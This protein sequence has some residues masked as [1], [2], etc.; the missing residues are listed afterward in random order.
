[1]HEGTTIP[2]NPRH[3]PLHGVRGGKVWQCNSNGL[4][5]LSSAFSLQRCRPYS[6]KKVEIQE[7]L[8]TFL[9]KEGLSLSVMTP[10]SR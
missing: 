6:A 2:R 10:P 4:G 7:N 3:L 5:R 8:F 1:M 9:C